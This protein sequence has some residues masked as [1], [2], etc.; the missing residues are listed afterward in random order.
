MSDKPT[1]GQAFPSKVISGKNYYGGAVSVTHSGMTMR[2]YFAAQAIPSLM[3]LDP[4]QVK[5]FLTNESLGDYVAR[6]AYR[7]ADFMLAERAK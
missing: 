1:G 3:D 4:S 6:K 2:D 7:I 5:D